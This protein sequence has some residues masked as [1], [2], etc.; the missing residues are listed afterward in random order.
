MRKYQKEGT[1]EKEDVPPCDPTVTVAM[2][3]E[4]RR[5]TRN[6]RADN[7]FWLKEGRKGASDH[8]NKRIVSDNFQNRVLQLLDSGRKSGRMG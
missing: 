1:K 8:R 6:K 2:V 5:K 3:G 4:S 7:M